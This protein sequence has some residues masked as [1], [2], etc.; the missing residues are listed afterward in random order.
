MRPTKD[1]VKAAVFS[2]LSARDLLRDAVVLDVYAG[3]GAL[4]IEALS[5]GAAAATF[6]EQDRDAASA[7]RANLAAC[8]FAG[9]V[10]ESDAGGFLRTAAR[11]MT[12]TSGSGATVDLA[13]VDPPYDLS[14]RELRPVLAGVAGLV[15]G[16]LI[17]LERPA[18]RRDPAPRDQADQGRASDRARVASRS[19]RARRDAGNDAGNDAGHEVYA[20]DDADLLPEWRTSWSR[21]FGDTLVTFWTP[22]AADDESRDTL[23]RPPT[24]RGDA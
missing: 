17:V 6:V 19:N 14:D 12:G 21:K 24:R 3:S 11:R 9:V 5:R 15:P 18:R 10:V 13:F 16:G 1:R 20:A 7:I 2:A 4:G 23:T 8:G 22:A